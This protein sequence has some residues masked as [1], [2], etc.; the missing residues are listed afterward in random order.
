MNT[1][2]SH[3]LEHEIHRRNEPNK[4]NHIIIFNL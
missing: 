3:R 1:V 2:T 4:K